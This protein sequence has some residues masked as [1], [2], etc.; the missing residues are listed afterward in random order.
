MRTAIAN[1]EKIVNYSKDLNINTTT[2]ILG[3]Y[4]YDMMFDLTNNIIDS[5]DS[6]ILSLV[7]SIFKCGTNASTFID[8]YLTF[9]LNVTK[10]CITQ[11]INTTTI[12]E[13][14]L[15]K[16]KYLTGIENNISYFKWLSNALLDVRE[17]LKFDV[18][19][20]TTL[21]LKLINLC[22]PSK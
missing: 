4:S 13:V 2:S 22:N 12:P 21:E 20:K 8:Q 1:L 15:E 3:N 14:M 19:S 6:N 10:Y 9:I 18:N 16:L 17:D 5:N 11:D 7:D